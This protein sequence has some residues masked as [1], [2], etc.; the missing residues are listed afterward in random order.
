MISLDG[1]PRVSAEMQE[2][3]KTH[4][5][6]N[7]ERYQKLQLDELAT[8]PIIEEKK[9]LQTVQLGNNIITKFQIPSY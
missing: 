2:K 9:D 1:N 3:V 5:K 8:K 6:Q 4:I 7:S